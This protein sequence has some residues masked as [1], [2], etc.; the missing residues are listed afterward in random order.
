MTLLEGGYKVTG[1]E[2]HYRSANPIYALGGNGKYF[3]G[4]KFE[5]KQFQKDVNK[6]LIDPQVA[7]DAFMRYANYGI[8]FGASWIPG[9]F[10]VKT[11]KTLLGWPI[12]PGKG[13][14]KIGDPSRTKPR[15]RGEKSLYDSEGG[16]WRWDASGHQP[17]YKPHWDYKAPGKNTP[18]I[19]IPPK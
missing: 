1:Y 17:D 3:M 14:F 11:F 18:W 5:N 8:A 16:E 6:G 2:Y 9:S 15:E 12:P 19:N 13:P 10:F 4:D 7:S